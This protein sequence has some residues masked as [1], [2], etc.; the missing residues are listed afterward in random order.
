MAN[1]W[2]ETLSGVRFRL[3]EQMHSGGWPFKDTVAAYFVHIPVRVGFDVRL[4]N[5]GPYDALAIN[6]GISSEKQVGDP[7]F[8]RAVFI[9]C[10]DHVA[11][12]LWLGSDRTRAT[13]RNLLSAGVAELIA[14]DDGLWLKF[15]GNIAQNFQNKANPEDVL[16]ALHETIDRSSSLAKK[17]VVEGDL[18]DYPVRKVF[19][20]RWGVIFLFLPLLCT[21]L[22]V[23]KV[24]FRGLVVPYQS[25]VR[26]Y[27]LGLALVSLALW[28]AWLWL[29]PRRSMRHRKAIWVA[30]GFYMVTASCFAVFANMNRWLDSRPG[31]AM[32]VDVRETRHVRN[33]KG[34]DGYEV[35]VRNWTKDRGYIWIEVTRDEYVA[36]RKLAQSC[37]T[38]ELST[39]AFGYQYM[40]DQQVVARPGEGGCAALAD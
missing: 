17:A 20:K 39:G 5:Q 27:L 11:A 3:L 19:G 15:D 10:D 36:A 8:D 1:K 26:D 2:H 24:Y 16:E 12:G 31:Q 23:P 6:L 18:P 35:E 40:K 29:G 37:L 21:F 32:S 28:F 25:V 14:N 30:A 33:V 7:D 34:P 4:R 9:E 22:F 13:V 38:F